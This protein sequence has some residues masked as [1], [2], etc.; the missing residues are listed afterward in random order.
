MGEKAGER[1]QF[2]I[3]HSEGSICKSL[4]IYRE[5]VG[6]YNQNNEEK[7]SKWIKTKQVKRRRRNK[8]FETLQEY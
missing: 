2:K 6:F 1:F 7:R 5:H 8:P 3:T 4:H